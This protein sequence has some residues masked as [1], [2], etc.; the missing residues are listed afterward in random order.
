MIIKLGLPEDYSINS[1]G[2]KFPDLFVSDSDKYSKKYIKSTIDYFQSYALREYKK[3]AETF[4]ENY[5]F[6]KGELR[7][8]D[9]YECEDEE[10]RGYYS[11]LTNDTPL[12]KYVQQYSIL[13]TPINTM[14]G[15]YIE[16]PD[17]VVV[18]AFDADSKSEELAYMTDLMTDYGTKMIQARIYQKAAES[19]VDLADEQVI[20]QIQE[21]LQKQ[22]AEGLDTFSTQGEKWANRILEALKRLFNVKDASGQGFRDLM[23]TGRNRFHIR[24]DNTPMGFTVENANPKNV[25]KYMDVN[26]KS[27]KKSIYAGLI[28]VKDITDIMNMVKLTAKEI[29]QLRDESRDFYLN[30]GGIRESNLFT[31]S[32]GLNSIN[33]NAG[34]PQPHRMQEEM[35]A[36]SALTRET[37]G[38][39]LFM[40]LEGSSLVGQKHIVTTAYW[41]AKKKI[42]ELTY[43]DQYGDEQKTFVNDTYKDGTHPGQLGDVEWTYVNEWWKGM[44]IG[45]CVYICEPLK[46]LDYCPILGIEFDGRNS[47]VKSMVDLMKPYQ[48][49]FNLCMNQLWELLSKE[50]GVVFE[51]NQ[52]HIPTD[53]DVP[54]KDSLEA[55]LAKAD[56]LGIVFS[57]DSLENMKSPSSSNT[58]VNRRIDLSRHQEMQ[59]RLAICQQIK[60]ECHALVGI[61]PERQGGIAATQTATGTQAALSSS[62]SQTQIWFEAQQ[63][64]MND[65][66]QA[67]ID[68]AQ[69]FE[70]SKEV[71]TVS[72]LNDE[73]DRAFFE[74]MGD[75]LKF[76]DFCC[77]IT[78]QTED[79][80]KLESLRAMSQ[81]LLQNGAGFYTVAKLQVTNSIRE[82][83]SGF[84]KN[85]ETI[86]AQKAQEQQIQQQQIQQQQQTA[87]AQLQQQAQ[88]EQAKIVNDN[89]NKQLDRVSRER[90]ALL[91]A[92]GRDSTLLNDADNNGTADA[93]DATAM[94]N[95][96]MMANK[97][98]ALEQARLNSQNAQQQAKN[99]QD[100]KKNSQEYD[101]KSRELDLKEKEINQRAAQ[102]KID[103]KIAKTNKN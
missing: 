76:R 75:D 63:Y 38:D 60:L 103:L 41:Q 86:E 30:P 39:E 54:L 23:I 36:E 72:Y 71:S 96:I 91:N 53:K 52:R 77:L 68:V 4:C 90:V 100:S 66:Y 101:L 81:N 17:N 93:L 89:Y 8:V 3:N 25:W 79:A 69:H 50:K 37:G 5:R 49:I 14:W 20:G 48:M 78:S 55:W 92:S 80:R 10:V 9:F 74:V 27:L 87:Q 65:V 46:I 31:N 28:E 94:S 73:G 88:T 83:M 58:N 102:A 64:V 11:D 6:L 21:E 61:N 1:Y 15:E 42:G 62:Y 34:I 26:E 47:P 12:P 13:N 45:N 44:K 84:K 70:S 19:G 35:F 40:R 2:T 18:K 7:A 32:T 29:Q 56:E 97:Q 67:I 22:V 33:Y 99:S 51:F 82:I 57:D 85:Q 98:H 59:S 16:K 24:E 43:I 95:D